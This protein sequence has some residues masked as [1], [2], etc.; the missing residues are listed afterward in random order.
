MRLDDHERLERSLLTLPIEE[1]VRYYDSLKEVRETLR[2][3]SG[4]EDWTVVREFQAEVN[5]AIAWELVRRDPTAVAKWL[6]SGEP[7]PAPFFG[8]ENG[9]PSDTNVREAKS[10][11]TLQIRTNLM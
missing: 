6:K 2:T 7:S 5:A 3:L 8:L 11:H 4:P 10:L 1:V 9:S